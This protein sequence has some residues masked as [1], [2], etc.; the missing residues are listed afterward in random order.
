MNIYNKFIHC[1]NGALVNNWYEEQILR[2]NTGEGRTIPG[3]HLPKTSKNE[4]FIRV[5][6]TDNTKT[7]IL[8]KEFQNDFSTTSNDLGKKKIEPRVGIKERIFQDFFKSYLN[9][10]C[11]FPK[12]QAEQ[13]NYPSDLTGTL[14]KTEV[15]V[16]HL[17]RKEII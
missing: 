6:E 13:T 9:Q 8:G 1:N 3:K 2:E 15:F 14:Q 10:G 5:Q 7:R 4:E 12:K 17:R 16:Y 11:I